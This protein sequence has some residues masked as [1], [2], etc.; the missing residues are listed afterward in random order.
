MNDHRDNDPFLL[1]ADVERKLLI[2][3]IEELEWL[4]PSD[5]RLTMLRREL[6]YVEGQIKQGHLYIPRF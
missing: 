4:D 5:D 2:Q 3:Q 6:S 1:S